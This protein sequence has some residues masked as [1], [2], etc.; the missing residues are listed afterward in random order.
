MNGVVVHAERRLDFAAHVAAVVIGSGIKSRDVAQDAARLGQIRL[1]PKRQLVASQCSGAL[2]LA[3]L[4]LLYDLAVCTDP[5][6]R[7]WLTE[8]GIPVIDQPFYAKGN[9]ATADGRL[10]SVCLARWIILHVGSW[11]DVVTALRR[12]ALIGQQTKY[13][14]RAI[15]AVEPYLPGSD[16]GPRPDPCNP[17]RRTDHADR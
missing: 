5:N 12:V 15:E 10:A 16:L 2:P 1:D 9:I 13:T 7:T 8:A 3:V 17:S 14:G 4:G 6:T 11:G